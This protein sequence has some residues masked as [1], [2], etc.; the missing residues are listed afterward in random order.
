MDESRTRGKRKASEMEACTTNGDGSTLGTL[1]ERLVQAMLEQQEHSTLTHITRLHSS[2]D[3]KADTKRK[4]S[5]H[6]QTMPRQSFP[7]RAELINGTISP[8]K[9][10]VKSL[11]L[12]HLATLEKRVK[13]ELQSHGFLSNGDDIK[14]AINGHSSIESESDTSDDDDVDE[15]LKEL[16]QRQAEL[17]QQATVNSRT[18]H[19][20]I[21]QCRRHIDVGSTRIRMTEADNRLLDLFTQYYRQVPKRKPCAKKERDALHAALDERKKALKAFDKADRALFVQSYLA[22]LSPLC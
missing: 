22:M 9:A 5:Q 19:N 13:C 18:L 4:K 10:L 3:I 11:N 21:D 16:R 1:T 20:L 6:N 17:H 12:A 8:N 7:V 15:V 14:P 2:D